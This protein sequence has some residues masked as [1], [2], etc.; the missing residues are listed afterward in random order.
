MSQT[1]V[2]FA[3]CEPLYDIGFALGVVAQKTT[4]FQMAVIYR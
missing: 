1:L 2:L 3:A 4:F